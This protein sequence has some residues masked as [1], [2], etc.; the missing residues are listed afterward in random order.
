MQMLESADIA[1]V[2][3]GALPPALFR[4]ARSAVARLGTQRLRESYFTTFWLPRDAPAVNP[5]EEAVAV[6]WRIA[7][8][9]PRCSGA[10]WWIGRSY[11]T[12]V[13]IG[14][15]FDQDVKA[16]RGL[17]HPIFSSVL[18]FNRVRGGQ[19][20]I[21]DQRAG[22]RGEPRPRV[23]GAL[24]A[25]APAPNRYVV[26]D[27]RLFHGVLDAK[28]STPGRKL[29]GPR[30]RLRLTLVVNFWTRRPSGVPEWRRA[31]TYRALGAVAAKE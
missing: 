5:V 14:F 11:T 31:S 26:F 29:A 16:R 28:G 21:T 19:L 9:G 17:R 15:H 13:P 3:E 24:Q 7:D 30:G 18:F 20:A 8:P 12:A 4:R 22:P 1:R 2:I 27:G 23:P 10:E 6:L 25:V